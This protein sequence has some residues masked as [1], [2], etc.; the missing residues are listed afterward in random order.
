MIGGWRGR[1][2]WIWK[3]AGTT[4]SIVLLAGVLSSTSEFCASLHGMSFQLEKTWFPI[5]AICETSGRPTTID[6]AVI[7]REFSR[8][9]IRYSRSLSTRAPFQSTFSPRL[10]S[11]NLESFVGPAASAALI[12]H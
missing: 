7:R 3:E 6:D 1:L 10:C 12:L 2:G 9:H 11:I 4:C 8:N 5:P